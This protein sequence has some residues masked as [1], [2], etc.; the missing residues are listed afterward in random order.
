MIR[1]GALR[2]RATIMRPVRAV[3]TT[4]EETVTYE[5]DFIA[6]AEL[7]GIRGVMVE[8][9]QQIAPDATH[10]IVI[11]FM[12]GRILNETRR[13]CVGVNEYDIIFVDDIMMKGRWWEL[14]VKQRLGADGDKTSY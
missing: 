3:S 6:F 13:I 14:H 10:K 5:E 1:S 4:G 12:A 11:R 9:A 2:H 8:N 7:K